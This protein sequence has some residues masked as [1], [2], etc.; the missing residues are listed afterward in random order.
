MALTLILYWGRGGKAGF[1][2]VYISV[3]LKFSLGQQGRG[4]RGWQVGSAARWN[5]GCE[6]ESMQGGEGGERLVMVP[7]NG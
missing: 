2:V 5:G 4:P 7:D 6:G 1:E 3:A